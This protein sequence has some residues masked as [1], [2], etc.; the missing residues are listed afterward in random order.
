MSSLP[1]ARGLLG[2]SRRCLSKSLGHAEPLS[3]SWKIKPGRGFQG[4]VGEEGGL[5]G[6]RIV[7]GGRTSIF[8]VRMERSLVGLGNR[9]HDAQVDGALMW[10]VATGGGDAGELSRGNSSMRPLLSHLHARG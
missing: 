1:G 8:K 5:V 9:G 6:A 4:K 7:L 2:A 3:P 10:S